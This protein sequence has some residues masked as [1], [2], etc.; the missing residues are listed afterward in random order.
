[1]HTK[2]DT[3]NPYG[4]NR[5]GFAWQHIPVGGAAH[6]DFGCGDGRFLKSL[7]SKGIK[8]LVGV[9]ISRDAVRQAYRA[10]GGL[11]ILHLAQ[12]T[13]L[14]FPDQLFS[15]ITLLDVL[16]H[17]AEER[18]LLEELHRVLRDD[19]TL[20]VTVPGRHCFSALD[21]GNLKFRFPGLHRWYYCRTH[22]AAAYERRYGANPD[23]LI[24]D[25]SAAKR[26]HEH[27]SAGRLAKLLHGSDFEATTF[28]GTGFFTRLLKI[29]D[30]LTGRRGSLHA[31]LA[32]ATAWDARHFE[33]AN[34][35]AVARKSAA[36]CQRQ[37]RPVQDDYDKVSHHVETADP[38]HVLQR[39][40]VGG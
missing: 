10:S 36:P 17:V 21:M 38:Q 32:T 22:S 19:G 15:S 1:M 39:S 4:C 34:I 6:L 24:G 5:Y 3:S 33:S 25:V 18:G 16:E 2:L 9:D 13:P 31:G 8:C 40:R 12:T 29:A 26:W 11:E 28:D 37:E 20:I 23:H 35:F 14:P 27:F 30:W 7:A